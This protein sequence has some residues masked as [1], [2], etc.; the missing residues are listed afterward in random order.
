MTKLHV[1]LVVLGL[2]SAAAVT[3]GG[4]AAAGAPAGA[5]AAAAPGHAHAPAQQHR[6]GAPRVVR[7]G[8]VDPRAGGFEIGLGEW[9]LTPEARA[10][11]PG[12]VTFVIRN[13]GRLVHGFEIEIR[14]RDDDH[15]SHRGHGGDDDDGYKAE[16]IEL[17]P[18]QST[19]MTLD[20]R[21]GVY[22]IECSVSNHDDMGMR[23]VLEVRA[24]AP[25]V[26]PRPAA[27]NGSTV[28]ITGFAFKP[29][30]LNVKA[31]TVVTWRNSDPAPHTATGK[32][33]SSPQL[34][35]GGTY[36]RRF[37][38]PGTYAYLCALHPGMRGTVVVAARGR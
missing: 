32:G 20:L 14:R 4:L 3:G 23:G 24:N 9:A 5:G 8:G 26:A 31:G 30:R 34:A 36:R 21:P 2:A 16:S 27:A 33:F 37:T 29:A 7:A 19:R 22:E 28:A 18:G 12:R 1:L 10:I 15:G 25:L 35:K 6:A 38:Q 11:R 17:R 13:R